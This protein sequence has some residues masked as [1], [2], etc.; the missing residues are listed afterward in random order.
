MK[1]LW[2][3]IPY[4]INSDNTFLNKELLNKYLDKFWLDIVMN[5]ND[6]EHILFIPRLI[7]ID[8]QYVSLSKM[9][10]INKDNKDEIISF[11]FDLIDLSNEAYKNIPIKSIIFSYG[12]RKGKIITDLRPLG[13][14]GDKI[15][16]Y[17]IYFKNKLPI[18]ILPLNYG[19]IIMNFNNNYLFSIG[20]NTIINLFQ[21]N[22]GENLINL[23]NYVKNG[24]V[25]FQWK[26]KILSW[27]EKDNKFIRF[28]GKSTIHYENGEKV[29]YKIEK[30]TSGITKKVLPKNIKLSNKFITMDL[31]TILIN[32]IHVPY[33]LCWYDGTLK[34]SYSYFINNLSPNLS[35][36]EDNILD[37]ITRAMRDI[38][39]KKY[40]G[41][42]IYL[43]NF[44]KFDGYFLL[45]YL[46]QIGNTSPTIHKGR[47][48]STKFS[49]KDSKYEV[50]FLDSL[51][52]L[53]SSLRKLCNSF[54]IETIKSIFP[55]KLHDINYKG[56]VPDFNLFCL[57]KGKG[58]ISL[59]EYNNYK[60]Q[61]CLSNKEWNFREE[62]I[63]YCSIDYV[64]LFQ[65]LTKFNHLIFK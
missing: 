54:N 16:K 56:L 63:K 13:L 57:A 61:Y 21:V 5:I 55:F 49:L 40:K 36:L 26:D 9:L 1:K 24:K 6:N 65:I 59:L 28:I 51:L 50:T 22:E 10:K 37:M 17:H 19:K 23:V 47:I 29:L 14:V 38:N 33:L 4:E 41:Y 42:R 31:E 12:I 30:K 43:H 53:P 15:I 46:S 27:G 44:A 60:D 64:S 11:L 20:K 39:R 7:L 35:Q 32:N 3:N 52:I 34:G 25:L 45:K 62:A 18:P 48:I 58:G 2:E 8:N